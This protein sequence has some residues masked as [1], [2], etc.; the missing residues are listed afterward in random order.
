M[1]RR[2]KTPLQPQERLEPRERI[3]LFLQRASELKQTGMLSNRQGYSM[4]AE[5]NLNGYK[6]SSNEPSVDELRSF[7]MIFRHFTLTRSN[8]HLPA[9]CKLCLKLITSESLKN[10]LRESKHKWLAEFKSSGFSIERDG[11]KFLPEEIFN[12]WIN[13]EYFHDN[14]EN[15]RLLGSL[16]A[17][18]RTLFRYNLIDFLW[19]ATNQIFR[20]ANIVSRALREKQIAF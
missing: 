9:I 10:E 1:A 15:I 14:T 6:I 5:L 3:D 18:E 16:T 4:T 19:G 12:L 8:V 2:V 13:G 7:L 17:D 11:R 20:V